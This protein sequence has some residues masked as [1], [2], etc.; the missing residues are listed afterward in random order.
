MY[1]GNTDSE[2]EF[3]PKCIEV[4]YAGT[5]QIGL[6]K[7]GSSRRV[8]GERIIRAAGRRKFNNIMNAHSLTQSPRRSSPDSAPRQSQIV[9]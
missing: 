6:G 5:I 4:N 1:V 9:L 8:E 2:L 7:V 3:S